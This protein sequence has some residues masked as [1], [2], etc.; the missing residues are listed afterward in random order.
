MKTTVNAIN[1]GLGTSVTTW[2]SVRAV[3]MFGGKDNKTNM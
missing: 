1:M 2:L 3:G